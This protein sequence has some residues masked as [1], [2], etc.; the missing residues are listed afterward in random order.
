MIQNEFHP[1][2]ASNT[3]HESRFIW[4]G[5]IVFTQIFLKTCTTMHYFTTSPGWLQHFG[6]YI[7]Q[8]IFIPPSLWLGETQFPFVANPPHPFIVDWPLIFPHLFFLLSLWKPIIELKCK[9]WFGGVI[10]ETASRRLLGIISGMFTGKP[11]INILA[12]VC[13]NWRITWDSNSVHGLNGQVPLRLTF[14][15]H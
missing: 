7:L 8:L 14:D 3:K 12:N 1:T 6:S 9:D 13:F 10:E 4:T 11:G 5:P 2:H 15:S